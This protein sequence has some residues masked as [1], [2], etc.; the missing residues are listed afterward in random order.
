MAMRPHGGLGPASIPA[1]CAPTLAAIEIECSLAATWSEHLSDAIP[2]PAAKVE[3]AP[4]DDDRIDVAENPESLPL[5]YSW[6]SSQD[7]LV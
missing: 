5:D 4:F 6:P 3:R 7:R 1:N 2:P